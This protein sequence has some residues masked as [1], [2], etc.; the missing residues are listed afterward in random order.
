MQHFALESVLVASHEDLGA[1]IRS[2]AA[3]MP[4]RRAVTH[5][6]RGEEEGPSVTYADL[7]RLARSLGALFQA[8]Q[9]QGQRAIMLF[10]AGVEPIAAFL[11]C[12]YSR[13]VAVPLPA[14][15]SGK[16]ERHLPRV[17]K[18]V[19]DADVKFVLTTTQIMNH[20]QELASKIPA[21]KQL[22]WIV[23]DSLPDLSDEWE[24]PLIHE[25][26]LAYLQY[27]SG[28]TSDPKGVMISHGNLLRICEYDS[29]LL[30]FPNKGTG[31]VCWMPYFHDA[32]LIEGLLVPLY[33]GLPVY[34]MSPLDFV[35]HPVR[36]LKAI[37][38]YRASHSAGP[39]CAFELCIRK[40]TPEQR[41]TLDL[42]SWRRASIAAEPISS[43]TIER[44]LDAFGPCGFSPE[45]MS[46]AWGLAEATLAVTATPGCTLHV[47]NAADLEQNRVVYSTGKGPARTMVGCGSVTQGPWTV[48]VKIVDPE[49]FKPSLAGTVGEAWVSG[50]MIAL[51]YWNRPEETA[52]TFHAQIAG[53]NGKRYLRTGDLGFMAGDEF[54]FTG[55]LKDLI[56]VEGRNH[57]PQDIEKT[58]E[59]SHPA[60]RPGCSIAFSLEEDSQVQVI[61]VA[62]LNKEWRVDDLSSPQ[63]DDSRVPVSRKEIEKAVRREVAEEHQIRVHSVVLIPTGTIPKTT[64]GKLQRGGCRQKFLA[65]A[66]SQKPEQAHL[67]SLTDS[68]PNLPGPDQYPK[69]AVLSGRRRMPTLS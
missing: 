36:W 35:A 63:T 14:P 56:I 27:T 53:G 68:V 41:K 57:Y 67:P 48:D 47:L 64:S 59:A 45:A 29:A 4:A 49:T 38:H 3:E 17:E 60:L 32:G 65:G 50:E 7:D 34:V 26:D 30:E 24:E 33:N 55:R 10:D 6:I 51:G 16:I 62:E 46:P 43:G 1:H 37:D 2:V 21:F 15:L 25:N 54:V 11:G 42:S 5:L 58:V 12:L 69:T 40:T 31:T 39:N 18:V 23:V 52:A 44:F 28:S 61:V 66:L 22:E 9:A 19:K 20:V 13:V 8:K